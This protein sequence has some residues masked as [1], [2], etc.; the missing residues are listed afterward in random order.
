MYGKGTNSA[1]DAR[2][3]TAKTIRPSQFPEFG[4]DSEPK[5]SEAESAPE[6]AGCPDSGSAVV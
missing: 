5:C 1:P 6:S 2:A 3:F 4:T